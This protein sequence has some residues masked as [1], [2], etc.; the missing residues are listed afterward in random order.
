MLF[1]ELSRQQVKNDANVITK[2]EIFYL[3]ITVKYKTQTYAHNRRI[4]LMLSKL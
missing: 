4:Q 3:F 2:K 1:Y